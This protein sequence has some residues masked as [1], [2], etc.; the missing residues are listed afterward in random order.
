MSDR[1][2]EELIARLRRLIAQSDVLMAQSRKLVEE[3]TRTH[4]MAKR[5]T[6]QVDSTQRSQHVRT[7]S[8]RVR[9]RD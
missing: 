9:V 6:K 8:R 3:A 7:H 4:T 5:A 2:V 1:E